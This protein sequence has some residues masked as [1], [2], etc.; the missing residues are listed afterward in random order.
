M[1]MKKNIPVAILLLGSLIRVDAQSWQTEL[2]S[3]LKIAEAQEMYHGQILIAEKGQVLFSHAYGNKE[4]GE[5]ITTQT[6][7]SIQ[8]VTKAFTALSILILQDQGLLHLDDRINKYLPELPYP[9]VTIRNLLNMTS[10]LPRFL[11]TVINYGDT[12]RQWHN[13]DIIQ[14][15]S[16]Y[17]PEAGSPGLEF[18]YN[19]DN[20]MLLASIVEIVSG[21]TYAGFVQH[22][23]FNPLGMKHSYAYEAGQEGSDQ[24]H[25]SGFYQVSGDGNI[26]S[27]AEDLYLFEQALYT[28][29]L[30]SPGKIRQMFEYTVLT[31]GT[32]SNYGFAW[33]LSMYDHMT[34]AYIV[35]DGD[36]C[37]AS[38][39]RYINEGKSFIYIHNVSG[40][41]WKEVYGAARNI[42]EG[43]PYT[44]PASRKVYDIDKTLYKEYIGEYL[45]EAFGLLHI[46][47]EN[48]RLYLRPDPIPGKEELIP[49]SQ[50]TFYFANQAIDWEFYLDDQGKV[51]GF[52]IKGMPESMGKKQ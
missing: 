24:P 31:D 11:P 49:S 7:L 48:G 50:T 40:R 46:S 6:P 39:Q 5:A 13:N 8:S 33:R 4:N 27:T 52:G 38:I 32:K 26:Y 22:H 18:H 15:V 10:G 1:N 2:D 20:Y 14:L 16:K 34:E 29:K 41:Y 28:D 19:T 30:L 9:E 35:G 47:E 3:V 45:S 21:E 25:S 43:K 36:N 51:I 17:K 44:I 12:T 42:W 37:R 23:I